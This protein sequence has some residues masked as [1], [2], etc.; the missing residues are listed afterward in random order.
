M[1][2]EIIEASE[3]GGKGGQWQI[4]QGNAHIEDRELH[5]SAIGGA[6]AERQQPWY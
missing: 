1:A 5:K 4:K 6:G 2:A 3:K